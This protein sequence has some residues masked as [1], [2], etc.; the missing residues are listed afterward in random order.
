MINATTCP[1]QRPNN[2]SS[3]AQKQRAASSVLQ[4]I[5]SP[6]E[7]RLEKAL[8][9]YRQAPLLRGFCNL[10]ERNLTFELDS[11]TFV[12]G[13]KLRFNAKLL[14][15]VESSALSE[16]D[17][18]QE[19]FWAILF[20]TS[21]FVLGY[22]QRLATATDPNDY[23]LKHISFT[24]A[25]LQQMQSLNVPQPTQSKLW[26]DLGYTFQPIISI[27]PSATV[28]DEISDMIRGKQVDPSKL[29]TVPRLQFSELQAAQGQMQ[30]FTPQT[31]DTFAQEMLND[32]V[33]EFA[34]LNTFGENSMN[35]VRLMYF[36]SKPP[37]DV[38]EALIDC[39]QSEY[40]ISDDLALYNNKKL[41]NDYYAPRKGDPIK[42]KTGHIE[43]FID[44][45]GS[46]SA[47][48]VGDCLKIFTDFFSKR[49]KK[50]TYAINT[51]DT[52]ILSRI[53]VNEEEDP[54]VKLKELAIV[55]GGGTDFRCIA[56]KVQALITEAAPGAN[57]KPYHCDL[58][59]VFTD[60][61]GC[62]PDTVPCDFVWVTT[63]KN[64]NL[65]AVTSVA[66]PGTVVYV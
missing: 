8:L 10:F 9:A 4:K 19:V 49:K 57:G 37:R 50:M 14:E 54:N 28:E 5:L 45:S 30:G 46:I 2:D 53:E 64:C 27:T 59:V 55:G 48:D 25:I 16:A 22:Q 20:H 38:S 18:N 41:A 36:K 58:A 24:Q 56:E 29:T 39:L 11:Q 13:D 62:F 32:W 23:L 15:A 61:A 1:N 26:T 43:L 21:Y 52:S 66:I 6:M 31:H 34:K 47:G 17:K 33:D 12:W 51:F 35:G 63:T 60:L 65:G 40:P 42:E 44:C 7:A 3:V